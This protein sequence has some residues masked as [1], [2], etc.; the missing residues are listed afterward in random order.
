MA[1][2]DGGPA[3]PGPALD[4]DGHPHDSFYRDGLSIR[5]YFAA[6][7]MQALCL[8][9]EDIN[10][11]TRVECAEQLAIRSYQIAD[12]MLKARAS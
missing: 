3:F 2:N 8:S 1:T 9:F 10:G 12:A 5:D 7:A 4:S 11:C 6:K